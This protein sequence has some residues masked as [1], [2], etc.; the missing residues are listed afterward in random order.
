[1]ACIT[2]WTQKNKFKGPTDDA[3]WWT[4]SIIYHNIIIIALKYTINVMHLNHPKANPPTSV[5]EKLSSTKLLPGAKNFADCWCKRCMRAGC[6]FSC[7]WLFMTIGTVAC[8]APLS[9]EFSSQ[10]YWG[11]FPCPPPVNLPNSEIEP[12]SLTSPAL[13]VVGVGWGL[14][15][16]C[17]LGRP[18]EYIGRT[19]LQL[20]WEQSK[21]CFCLVNFI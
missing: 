12:T 6:H 8:Q 17:H 14:Y 4:V 5:M 9:M 10:E 21:M 18:K 7:V 16:L 11:G 19:K 15:Y 3:L 13:V 2:T 1:M 20:T